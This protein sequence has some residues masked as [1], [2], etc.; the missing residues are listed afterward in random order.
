MPFLTLT[1][2]IIVLNFKEKPIVAVIYLRPLLGYPDHPGLDAVIEMAIEDLNI[3]KKC[4]VDAA[5]LENEHDRPYTL[6]ASKEVIASMAVVGHA[7]KR[8]APEYCLGSEFL[9]NDP[10]ASL[11]V[12]KA[13]QHQFIRTD[14]F[15]DRMSREEYG[16]EI[17]I[18][19]KGL[20]AYRDKIQAQNIQ[21][22]TDIQVKYATLLEQ[23][24]LAQSAKE[25]FEHQSSAAVVSGKITGV[26]PEQSEIIEAKSGAPELPILI[27]SGL[28]RK[29]IPE[30][31]PH[32]DG[33]IVGSALMSN[34]RMD[35]EKVAP[36][37]D[38]IR[39]Y[40][41]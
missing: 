6:K 34:T 15:V 35:Y 39:K 22:L 10:E 24:S 20:I 12:A 18:D 11:A 41:N 7:L 8:E 9:I 3:L 26:A 1:Q 14:Y 23:K 37:M 5:L 29:N 16:G 25:A 40:R 32:L 4:G 38:L 31:F 19:P 28:N 33:A 21:L 36:F 30:L 17:E 27:G 13:S 2:G